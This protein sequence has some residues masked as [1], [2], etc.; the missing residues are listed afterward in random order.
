VARNYVVHFQYDMIDELFVYTM[1]TRHL[2]YGKNVSFG[3]I[4]STYI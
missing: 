2:D 4:N 3:N 1:D